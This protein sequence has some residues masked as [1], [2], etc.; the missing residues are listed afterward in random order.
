LLF[1]TIKSGVQQQQTIG[2]AKTGDMID[3]I[4]IFF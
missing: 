1:F 3:S 4:I 2:I